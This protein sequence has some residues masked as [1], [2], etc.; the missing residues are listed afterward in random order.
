MDWSQD[1]SLC[2]EP[3]WARVFKFQEAPTTVAPLIST[4]ENIYD[5]KRWFETEHPKL[6][7]SESGLVLILA[8]RNGEK[9]FPPVNRVKSN[10]WLEM[11]SQA[12]PTAGILPEKPINTTTS[13]TGGRRTSRILPFSEHSFQKIVERFYIH[14][15]IARVINRADIPTFSARELEMGD[16]NGQTYPAFVYNCRTSNAWNNDLAFSATYFPHCGL[17]Y[18]IM[19]GCPMSVEVQILNRLNRVTS[20]A[21]HPLLMPGIFMELERLRHVRLVDETIDDLEA[22]IQEIDLVFNDTETVSA[23]ENAARKEAKRSAWLDTMFLRNQ[24]VNWITYL[25]KLIDHADELNRTV[26]G[27]SEARIAAFEEDVEENFEERTGA[28]EIMNEYQHV[29]SYSSSSQDLTFHRLREGRGAAGI[30]E[31][32]GDEKVH[33]SLCKDVNSLCQRQQRPQELDGC[34]E[35]SDGAKEIMSRTGNKIK[36]RVQD[37]IDEYHE[38]VR[39][40]TM[41]VDGTRRNKYGDRKGCQP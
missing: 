6:D 26:F 28:E 15:T 8:R 27:I 20:E 38:K 9:E 31:S 19:F 16:N 12:R 30:D 39:D 7:E 37:I 3:E 29:H 32:Y 4:M 18:A 13:T 1:N 35:R 36:Y 22:R 17:T 23:E 5:W 11:V 40:C 14:E 10:K 24:L 34:Q 25:E 2:T 33:Y 41:R 21:S